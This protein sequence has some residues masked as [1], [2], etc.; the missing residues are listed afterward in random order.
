[1][2]QNQRKYATERIESIAKAKIAAIKAAN[3]TPAIK[4]A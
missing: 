2:N 3:T 1:M 4:A